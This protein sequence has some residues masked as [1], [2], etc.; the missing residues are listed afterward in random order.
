MDVI[1]VCPPFINGFYPSYGLSLLKAELTRNKIRSKIIYANLILKKKL[2]LFDFYELIC[3]SVNLFQIG[4]Y[5]FARAAFPE[6]NC[7]LKRLKERYT[8]SEY[9]KIFGGRN[10]SLSELEKI[11]DLV[12]G[13]IDETVSLILSQK[14]KIVGFGITFSQINSSIALA[15][16]IKRR[17]PDILTVFGGYMAKRPMSEQIL[18]ISRCLDYAFDGEAEFEFV[19]FAGLVNDKRNL[20]DDK[21][22]TCGRIADLDSLQF[23]DYTDFF[24]QID[25]L[26]IENRRMIPFESSRGCWWGQGSQCLFCGAGENLEY[27]QK[28][29][30]RINIELNYLEKKYKPDQIIGVDNVI[31]LKYFKDTRPINKKKIPIFYEVRSNLDQDMIFGLRKSG[32]IHLQSGIETLNTGL[33]GILKKGTSAVQNIR[34]LRDCRRAGTNIIWSLMYGI[35]GEHVEDY[36]LMMEIFP[37]IFHLPPP[38]LV[39]PLFLQRFSPLFEEKDNTLINGIKPYESLKNCFP[40][41]TD[42]YDLSIYFKADYHTVFGDFS[43]LANLFFSMIRDWCGFYRTKKEFSVKKSDGG[44]ILVIDTRPISKHESIYINDKKQKIFEYLDIPVEDE[45]VMAMIKEEDIENDF[46]EMIENNYILSLDGFY[47]SPI[48]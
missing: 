8:E 41:E 12:P 36:L 13:F 28:S 19:K 37:F 9:E 38:S 26:K 1:L 14:P 45:I 18:K 16:E 25:M 11:T 5:V 30:R 44:R 32:I 17:N 7:N 35:P 33:L 42:V 15:R 20:P 48:L 39:L 21:I 24:F 43:E 3:S 23:P 47:F 2:M 27:R 4:E 10:T 31:P 46:Y 29:G 22:I 34:F 40:D 6:L